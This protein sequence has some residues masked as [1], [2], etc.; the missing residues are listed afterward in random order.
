MKFC[1]DYIYLHN[2]GTTIYA[3]FNNLTNKNSLMNVGK[4]V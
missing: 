1:V 4:R 3:L 2:G